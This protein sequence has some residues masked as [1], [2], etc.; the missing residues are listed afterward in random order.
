[1]YKVVCDKS[2]QLVDLTVVHSMV[3]S[4]ISSANN[5]VSCKHWAKLI[6]DSLE[7]ALSHYCL[8][9]SIFNV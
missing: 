4:F 7:R 6:V 5:S 2:K 3:N 9:Q 8:V 1:M